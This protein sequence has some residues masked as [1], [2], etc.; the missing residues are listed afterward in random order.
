MFFRRRQEKLSKIIELYMWA[1]KHAYQDDCQG[2][3]SVE[4]VLK[5]FNVAYEPIRI[6]AEN[7][8]ATLAFLPRIL[9]KLLPFRSEKTYQLIKS[10]YQ[11]EPFL[12]DEPTLDEYLDCV[13]N[14][15]SRLVSKDDGSSLNDPIY[16]MAKHACGRLFGS[17]HQMNLALIALLENRIESTLQYQI[18][19]MKKAIETV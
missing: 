9:P 15:Y 2:S 13:V 14:A 4:E 3:N 19:V 10:Q 18:D 8:H 12:I 11:Q 16:C 17:E 5:R 7:N 6:A 1:M